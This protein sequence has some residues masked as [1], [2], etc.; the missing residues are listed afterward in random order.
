MRKVYFALSLIALAGCSGIPTSEDVQNN[1]QERSNMQA[2]QA[3]GMPAIR[4]F[5]EK[6]QLKL[7]LEKRDNAFPTVSYTQDRFGKLH[8]LCDSIGYGIPGAT[9]YTNPLQATGYSSSEV[10][11]SQ[12]DPNGLYSPSSSASTWVMCL[13]KNKTMEATYIEDNVDV[14]PADVIPSN[15]A[16]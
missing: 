15:L 8:K 16:Q 5:W 1:A 14:F 12:A 2:V 7:I 10:A 3:V 6:R 4:N 11:I 13:S 9:Q